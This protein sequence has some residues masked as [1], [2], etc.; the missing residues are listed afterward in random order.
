[1]NKTMGGVSKRSPSIL[2]CSIAPGSMPPHSSDESLSSRRTSKVSPSLLLS[3]IVTH[4][5]HC[6]SSFLFSLH[7]SQQLHLVACNY[8]WSPSLHPWLDSESSTAVVDGSIQVDPANILSVL[9]PP[10]LSHHLEPSR[11]ITHEGSLKHH[12]L[13]HG[14]HVHHHF[15]FL[16]HGTN[17]WRRI[18]R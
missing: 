17:S 6:S 13:S 7:L 16:F 11:W 12:P 2:Y 8:H 18:P 14:S 1:M 5:I 15:A 4:Q 10:Q 9:N 3:K